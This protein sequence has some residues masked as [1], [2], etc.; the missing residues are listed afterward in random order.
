M[1]REISQFACHLTGRELRER[2]RQIKQTL[3]GKIQQ[4]TEL[5]A[6]VELIFGQPNADLLLSIVELVRLEHQCCP[7]FQFTLIIGPEAEPVRLRVTGPDG[8][9]DLMR[10]LFGN[11]P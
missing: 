2:K 9:R 6:G 10:G 3:L 7:F 1:N 11:A 4:T 5:Q 8:A